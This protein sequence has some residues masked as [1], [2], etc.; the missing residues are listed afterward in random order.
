M[1]ITKKESRKFSPYM[2]KNAK[3]ADDLE[4]V[5]VTKNNNTKHN[6]KQQ[7]GEKDTKS[8]HTFIEPEKNAKYKTVDVTKQPQ[9]SEKH[10]RYCSNTT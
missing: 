6:T 5:T 9:Q 8:K 10:S 2:R 4:S 7:D 1:S 3:I